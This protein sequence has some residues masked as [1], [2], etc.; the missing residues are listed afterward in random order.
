MRRKQTRSAGRE[1]PECDRVKGE[2]R[3]IK[4]APGGAARLAEE[5]E[6]KGQVSLS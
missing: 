3:A 4:A 5:V 2:D 1:A 6:E